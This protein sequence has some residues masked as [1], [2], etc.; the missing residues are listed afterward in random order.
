MRERKATKQGHPLHAVIALRD[1]AV[2]ERR[3]RAG[4]TTRDGQNVAVA[5]LPE[6]RL[7]VP[8]KS[9]F[10]HIEAFHRAG[11][12]PI[13][14]LPLV[15]RAPKVIDAAASG[16]SQNQA[17]IAK[18]KNVAAGV[19]PGL[20]SD[21]RHIFRDDLQ[22]VP[23]LAA[24]GG[25]VDVTVD[26][27]IA[28]SHIL[29]QQVRRDEQRP[30]AQHAE[31]GFASQQR[32]NLSLAPRLSTI[33]R[34]IVDHVFA[35]LAASLIDPVEHDEQQLATSQQCQRRLVVAGDAERNPLGRNPRRQRLRITNCDERLFRRSAQNNATATAIHH[36]HQEQ[37]DAADNPPAE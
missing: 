1:L 14:C 36:A 21:S 22:R 11:Q 19:R 29:R 20:R 26:V 5:C 18:L 35:G 3:Q 4:V 2:L 13:P 30:V 31:I 28:I 12:R 7:R 8:G 33:G 23:G 25:A 24:I 37:A 34:T 6:D 27:A 17:A 15:L 32:Q 9:V 16:D 10:L